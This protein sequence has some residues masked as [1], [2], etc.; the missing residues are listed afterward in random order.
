LK[1]Q[2]PGELFQAGYHDVSYTAED[3]SG[4]VAK[5]QFTIHVTG[6]V[7]PNQDN[8]SPITKVGKIII[9]IIHFLNILINYSFI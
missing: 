6:L 2:E 3:A 1:F 9:F 7:F 5:C 4:N 8:S